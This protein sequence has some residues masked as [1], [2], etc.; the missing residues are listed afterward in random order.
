MPPKVD[1]S[2]GAMF[3]KALFS[4]LSTGAVFSKAKKSPQRP[5]FL[6]LSIGAV[7][8]SDFGD[9]GDF[10]GLGWSWVVLGGLGEPFS[11]ICRQVQCFRTARG[12]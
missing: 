6:D 4:D 9:F 5:V 11:R 3:S 12:A 2:T 8:S 1:L 10:G 7:F